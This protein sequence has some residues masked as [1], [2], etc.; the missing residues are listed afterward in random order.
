MTLVLDDV[1]ARRAGRRVLDGVSARVSRGEVLAAVGANGAGK[2]TLLSIVAGVLAPDRGGVTIAGASVW[3]PARERVV[4]RGRLGFVPEAADPPGHLTGE[5]LLAL[6]A[7]V[8]RAEPLG[9]ALRARLGLDAIAPSRIDR[10]SLGQR[11]RICLGAA[12]VGDPVLLVL[13][14]PTN[15]LD[16]DGALVLLDL[17]IE[18]ARAGTAILMTSHD[19]DFLDRLGA[20]RLPLEAGRP[21]PSSQV[22]DP[23]LDHTEAGD[24]S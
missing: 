6:V 18:R 9:A 24:R 3:G 10:M 17:L 8:K 13:D 12:L 20:R 16:A 7:G 14:E 2:S 1:G 23:R 19:A 11:R 21:L 15:G 22:A 5:E 4:A